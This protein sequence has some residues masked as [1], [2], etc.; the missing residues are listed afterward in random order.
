MPITETVDYAEFLEE[1]KYQTLIHDW[2]L[3]LL[4][5]FQFQTKNHRHARSINSDGNYFV[6]L[7]RRTT[8]VSFL[9][10]SF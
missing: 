9:T 7:K 4:C 1:T 3:S 6:L 5:N 10:Y 2:Y 8:D